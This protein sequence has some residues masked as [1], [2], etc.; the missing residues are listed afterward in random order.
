MGEI[1]GEFPCI[2]PNYVGVK[3]QYGYMLQ[4]GLLGSLRQWQY[5][6][7]GIVYTSLVK[8]DLQKGEVIDR[9]DSERG[10]YIFEP[11]FVPRVGS[12]AEDDGFLAAFATNAAEDQSFMLILDASDLSKGP[13]SQIKLPQKVASGLH[14]CFVPL[15]SGN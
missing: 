7:I 2:N 12:K 10:M 1:A 3:A 5:P 15:E 6:P 8:Y 14:G 13:V 4:D 11:Q 9:W